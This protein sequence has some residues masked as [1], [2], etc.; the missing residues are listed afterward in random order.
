MQGAIIWT[1]DPILGLLVLNLIEF[2][3]HAESNYGNRILDFENLF[4]KVK[5]L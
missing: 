5:P 2:I 4:K 1:A 3:I